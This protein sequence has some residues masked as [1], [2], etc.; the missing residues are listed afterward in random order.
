MSAAIDPEVEMQEPSDWFVA[1]FLAVVVWLVTTLFPA[2]ADARP[3]APNT[4]ENWG[5]E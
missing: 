2:R 4:F 5:C 1:L 3:T